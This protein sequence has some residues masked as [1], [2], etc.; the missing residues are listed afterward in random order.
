MAAGIAGFIVIEGYSLLDAFYMTVITLATVGFT[1]VQPLG[2]AGKLFTSMLILVGLGIVAYAASTVA[3]IIIEGRVFQ[4]R[5]S[6]KRVLK[7]EQ[8]VIVCGYGR[9]GQRIV[10]TL[11]ERRI[12][13]V[14]VERDERVITAIKERGFHCIEGNAVDDE[15]LVKANIANAR[16]LVTSLNSDADNVYVVLTARSMN[17]TLYIVARAGDKASE[18]KLLR[19]GANRVVSPYE[20]GGAYMANAVMRP[21]VVDFMEVVSAAHSD[22]TRDLEIDEV[23]IPYNSPII[24]KQLRETPIRK[25]LNIIV[26]AIKNEH[27]DIEYNPSPDRVLTAGDTLICVGFIDK[28]DAFAHAIQE[29]KRS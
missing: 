18:A 3:Q 13:F 15:S 4:K 20:I 8:H 23:V 10:Q 7:M 24:G 28:I 11:V 26:L 22:R 19:A 25:D 21:T 16:S 5:R 6:E 9:I 2:P 17:P 29:A 14:V 12:P 27:G 1:E